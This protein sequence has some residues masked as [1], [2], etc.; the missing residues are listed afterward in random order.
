MLKSM[1]KDNGKIY[2]KLGVASSVLSLACMII[3]YSLDPVTADST[4][5]SIGYI[6]SISIFSLLSYVFLAFSMVF[7]LSIVLKKD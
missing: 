6:K 7:F 4:S 1:K 3:S 5:I 2:F